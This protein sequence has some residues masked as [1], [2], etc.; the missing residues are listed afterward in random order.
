MSENDVRDGLRGALSGEPPLDFDPDALVDTVRK[1]VRRRALLSVGVATVAVVAAAVAVPLALSGAGEGGGVQVADRPAATGQAN[2][3]SP[4]QAPQ[5]IE[6][7]PPGTEPVT[8]TA[9]E[10][11]VRATEMREHLAVALPTLLPD[12][13]DFEVG[14]FGGESEGA[15]ADDQNYLNAFATF[16]LD[17]ARFG[18]AVNVYAPGT[19]SESPAELC[20]RSTCVD[21]SAVDDGH[22]VTNSEDYGEAKIVS[23]HHFRDSGG[24]VFVSGYN[25]D[26]TSQTGPTYSTT[27][28]VGADLLSTLAT[29]PQFDL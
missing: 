7:P 14:L 26:P 18:L 12:A 3:E 15:V 19:S 22:V 21:E 8:Y 13:T 4:T 16:T 6:W 2:T 23:V 27:I 20:D 29:D 5:E 1:Q 9:A 17:G 28:P 11:Q 25:Y 10:L 24:S